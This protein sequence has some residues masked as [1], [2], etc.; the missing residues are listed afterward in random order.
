MP[1]IR[2]LTLLMIVNLIAWPHIEAM[3]VGK[4]VQTIWDGQSAGFLITWTTSDIRA[5][6]AKDGSLVFSATQFAREDFQASEA[7]TRKDNARINRESKR[8]GGLS[9]R[10]NHVNKEVV[11]LP[12]GTPLDY[13]CYQ[14]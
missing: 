11:L 14:Y 3:R 13:V 9:G 2:Q 6:S 10:I 4:E 7:E 8:N 1:V 5:R 12:S